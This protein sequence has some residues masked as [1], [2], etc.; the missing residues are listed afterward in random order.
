MTSAMRPAGGFS[1]SPDLSLFEPALSRSCPACQREPQAPFVTCP[2]A[3]G[4]AWYSPCQS[5][6]NR[7]RP[8]SAKVCAD[9]MQQDA[10][11]HFWLGR[12][13]VPSRHAIQYE[14]DNCGRQ[15]LFAPLL[16]IEE[17]RQ[18]GQTVQQQR[19]KTGQD[20]RARGTGHEAMG[21]VRGGAGLGG[22]RRG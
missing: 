2:N 13:D 19:P 10:S 14:R 21:D 20:K 18:L 1:C 16:R 15:S 4:N 5:R 8:P 22:M 3:V 17:S 6:N 9:H 11:A 12:T 7:A